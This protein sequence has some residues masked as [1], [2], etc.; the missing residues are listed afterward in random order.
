MKRCAV[1][2]LSGHGSLAPSDAVPV[3][4]AHYSAIVPRERRLGVMPTVDLLRC[5]NFPI[6]AAPSAKKDI[7][8]KIFCWRAAA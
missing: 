8:G 6:S 4:R 5:P 2:A 3:S 1:E 7:Q